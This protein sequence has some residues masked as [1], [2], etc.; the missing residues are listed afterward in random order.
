M[1]IA[2]PPGSEWPLLRLL[3]RFP[4][5]RNPPSRRHPYQG[6]DRILAGCCEWG[7]LR[8]RS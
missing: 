3:A 1:A 2:T 8:R 7:G 4:I 5:Y 6:A